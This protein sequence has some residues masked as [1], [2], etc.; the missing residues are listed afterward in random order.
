M[1][2]CFRNFEKDEN[3]IKIAKKLKKNIKKMKEKID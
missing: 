3:A 2:M 1:T